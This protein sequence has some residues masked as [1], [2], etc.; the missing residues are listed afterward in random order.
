MPFVVYVT[1]DML[2]ELV[3]RIIIMKKI[4][5][6]AAALCFATFAVAQEV[7]SETPVK[8]DE[9]KTFTCGECGKSVEMKMPKFNRAPRG[10]RPEMKKDGEKAR[11]P[12]GPRPEM[13]KDGEKVR[14]PRGAR[15]EMKKDG[16]KARGPRGAR[17]EMKKDGEKARG[18]RG[19]RPKM[20]QFKPLC[21]ECFK[22]KMP[23]QAPVA[24][25][26]VESAE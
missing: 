4:T 13:K 12:R 18:P 16:E 26:E 9:T 7:A 24:Q 25:V 8:V 3:E 2:H 11:A 17:P 23:Q 22:A 1:H 5:F 15:P 21:K 14:G 10:A 20:K 6:F 19:P